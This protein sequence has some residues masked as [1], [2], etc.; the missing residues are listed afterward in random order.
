[1]F[2]YNLQNPT[3]HK[4]YKLHDIN[5][6]TLS[7]K[8]IPIDKYNDFSIY[9]SNPLNSS[10]SW[11]RNNYWTISRTNGYSKLSIR[12][13]KFNNIDVLSNKITALNPDITPLS[14]LVE[15]DNYFYIDK[16]IYNQNGYNE[17]FRAK[18]YIDD[19]N[20]NLNSNDVKQNNY[21]FHVIPTH[22]IDNNKTINTILTPNSN[23]NKV[24][25]NL[26]L[27]DNINLQLKDN[28]NLQ[29]KDNINLQ[30]KDNINFYILKSTP[31][32]LIDNEFKYTKILTHI[33][34][35]Y[36]RTYDIFCKIIYDIDRLDNIL[37]TINNLIEREIDLYCI[38][39]PLK[40]QKNNL[41]TKINDFLKSLHNQL[42]LIND[43]DLS[44][45]S[46]QNNYIDVINSVNL[47]NKN[48][49]IDNFIILYN[50][51]CTIIYNLNENLNEIMES[52]Q[53][54]I[55]IRKKGI[56]IGNAEFEIM[57]QYYKAKNTVMDLINIFHTKQHNNINDF[58]YNYDANTIDNNNNDNI[59]DNNNDN[60]NDN[61]NDNDKDNDNN[62]NNDNNNNDNNNNS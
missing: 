21:W 18:I 53:S 59:N 42:Y 28:I 61:N 23:D 43:L 57:E 10:L 8:N 60:H 4:V 14:H 56:N 48:N 46:T 25:V 33:Q 44:F 26:Q 13:I 58:E 39:E 30:L 22:L 36:I 17:N 20:F 55:D 19:D 47:S 38:I 7:S 24:G 32:E 15:S 49:N 1:M 41:N 51:I 3:W 5:V 40:I 35:Y 34:N 29:P 31:V 62:D 16:I 45:I 54:I 52:R 27:K 2:T 50:V 9:T 11:K 6:V 12:I 37:I